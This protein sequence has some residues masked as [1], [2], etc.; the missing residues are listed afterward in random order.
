[1]SNDYVLASPV[2]SMRLERQADLH[3]RE[4]PLQHIR[5]DKGAKFL[6][7]G[8]GSG[9]VARKV[10]QA[11]PNA[12]VIGIDYTPSYVADARTLAAAD[13]VTNCAF[14]I[15]DLMTLP[16]PDASFDVVWSQFVLYFVPDAKQV[17]REFRRVTKP[18]GVVISA[19][20]KLAP[21][22]DPPFEEQANLDRVFDNAIGRCPPER[23]PRLFAAAGLVDVQV[24]VEL[25]TIYSK[26]GGPIDAPH[27]RNYEEVL[28]FVPEDLRGAVDAWFGFL[29]RPDS[30]AISGYWI[31]SGRVPN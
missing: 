17:V 4:R 20:H 5:L 25:D 29:D 8:C 30:T 14:E 2:E 26:V 12:D 27:R 22:A 7:A 9:W 21:V 3:G 13:G 18:G 10:A 19:L 15:G 23:L 6:D 31:T 11:Y 16:F 1:M 28:Q 24:K